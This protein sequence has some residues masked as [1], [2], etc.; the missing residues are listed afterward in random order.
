MTIS[1]TYSTKMIVVFDD[2]YEVHHCGTLD[3]AR[4]IIEHG[5][6]EYGFDKADVIDAETGEV[7]AMAEN[8]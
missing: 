6:Y 5:F 1:Y 4:D 8:D 2:I 7:L 3:E